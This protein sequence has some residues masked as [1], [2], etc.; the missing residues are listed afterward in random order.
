VALCPGIRFWLRTKS[1]RTFTDLLELSWLRLLPLQCTIVTQRTHYCVSFVLW[2]H[3]EDH[4]IRVFS[5]SSPIMLI[6]TRSRGSQS[7]LPRRSAHRLRIIF[8][9]RLRPKTAPMTYEENSLQYIHGKHLI[10]FYI[11]LTFWRIWRWP[12]MAYADWDLCP[13]TNRGLLGPFYWHTSQHTCTKKCVNNTVITLLVLIVRYAL[14]S[15][16]FQA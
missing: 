3:G 1:W 8:G 4:S 10:Y 15:I 2:E 11:I 12:K 13:W 14:I 9:R 5:S 6:I 16:C 7:M